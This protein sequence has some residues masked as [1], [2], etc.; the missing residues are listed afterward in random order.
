VS[1]IF[2]SATVEQ[3]EEGISET[4][5]SAAIGVYSEG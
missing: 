3:F 4:I 2:S 5:M 1:P